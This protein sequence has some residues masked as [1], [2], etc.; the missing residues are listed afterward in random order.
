MQRVA[1]LTLVIASLGC[2]PVA[3]HEESPSDAYVA[4][5][6]GKAVVRIHA[7]MSIEDA[8]AEATRACEHLAAGIE[9]DQEAEGV[10]DFIYMTLDKL[11]S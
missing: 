6:I 8:T 1:A 5:V 7:R 2:G 3:A 11:A 4:C 9:E 10:S